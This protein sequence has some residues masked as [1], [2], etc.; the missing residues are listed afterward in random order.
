MVVRLNM[1]DNEVRYDANTLFHGHF[2]CKKC[3]KIYDFKINCID[4][5]LENV[6]IEKRYVNYLGTCKE[7]LNKEHSC[8]D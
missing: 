3:G 7:C 5:N 1:H 8:N 6:K 4:T 2:N